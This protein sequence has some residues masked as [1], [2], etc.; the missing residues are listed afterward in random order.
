VTDFPFYDSHIP[1]PPPARCTRPLLVSRFRTLFFAPPYSSPCL[2]LPPVPMVF[3]FV[4]LSQP[5]LFSFRSVP[6]PLIFSLKMKFLF[7]S[8]S[9]LPMLRPVSFPHLQ[10][11]F[12]LYRPEDSYRPPFLKAISLAPPIRISLKT[13]CFIASR[14]SFE[15]FC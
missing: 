7:S 5:L 2:I 11:F 4:P 6:L 1:S 13:F 14:S 3:G 10:L 9:K 12:P 15:V 8:L